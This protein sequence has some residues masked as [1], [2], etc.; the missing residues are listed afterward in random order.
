MLNSK[1]H[2]RRAVAALTRTA[3][4]GPEEANFILIGMTPVGIDV[5]SYR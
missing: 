1:Q 2:H 3:H 5:V 4:L